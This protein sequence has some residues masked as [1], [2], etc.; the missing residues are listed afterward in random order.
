MQSNYINLALKTDAHSIRGLCGKPSVSRGIN[1]NKM[2]A[3]WKDIVGYENDYEISIIGQV[4]SK[5][6]G[7]NITLK[8]QMA[9][10]GYYYVKLLLSGKR[11][12]AFIHRLMAIH[13]IENTLN[14]KEVNHIDGNKLNNQLNN[15]EWVTPSENQRHAVN[16]LLKPTGEF[17]SNCKLKDWQVLEIIEWQKA[18]IRQ[19]TVAKKYGVSQSTIRLI[20]LGKRR[21]TKRI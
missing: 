13:F 10:A 2:A 8:Y 20:Y 16:T 15:L 7:K 3:I 14:K 9:T 6:K 11:K 19:T 1:N 5:K 21:V 4:R 12:N 18:G 17:V